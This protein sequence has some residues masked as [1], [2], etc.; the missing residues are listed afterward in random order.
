MNWTKRMD[1]LM[2]RSNRLRLQR[3]EAWAQVFAQTRGSR[4][5]L[6]AD[7]EQR[8][9]RRSLEQIENE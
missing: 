6:V 2:A 7:A 3:E 1:R 9:I 4:D 8:R 5:A